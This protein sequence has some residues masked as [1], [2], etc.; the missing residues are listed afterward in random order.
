MRDT[1]SPLFLSNLGLEIYCCTE[2][3]SHDIASSSRA[4]SRRPSELSL[5]EHLLTL[6]KETLMH[7]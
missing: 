1:T 4:A 3:G 7:V 6:Q 2:L 5:N